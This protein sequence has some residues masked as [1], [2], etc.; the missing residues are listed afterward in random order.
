[1]FLFFTITRRSPI[2]SANAGLNDSIPLGL[3]E[4]SPQFQLRVK[5]QNKSSP[6]GA[7]ENSDIARFCHP[8]GAFRFST[9][10]PQL[11]LRAIF[12]RASGVQPHHETA[13]AINGP[14]AK[15]SLISSA[16]GSFISSA[17]LNL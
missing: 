13:G 5:R 1:L 9:A 4:N 12:F 3:T 15:V 8:S 6:A 2:S 14:F 11:K 17:R 16:F 10:N 7:A